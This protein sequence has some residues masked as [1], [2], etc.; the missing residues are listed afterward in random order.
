M[1]HESANESSEITIQISKIDVRP[2]SEGGC[3]RGYRVPDRPRGDQPEQAEAG[4]AGL[5]GRHGQGQWLQQE[6]K[7]V[8]TEAGFSVANDASNDPI[9]QKISKNV[10]S[11]KHNF[12]I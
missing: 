7:T 9:C 3:G 5:P 1:T 11:E 4:R 6:G 8:E 12:N 2:F 10:I